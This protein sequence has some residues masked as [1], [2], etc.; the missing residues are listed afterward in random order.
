MFDFHNASTIR[1]HR[2][3]QQAK[4]LLSFKSEDKGHQASLIKGITTQEFEA[5]YPKD[6]YESFSFQA[7]ERF[8]ADLVK[9]NENDLVKAEGQFNEG[10]QN[11]QPVVVENNGSKKLVYV[12]KKD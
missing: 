12:R 3:L 4:M 5:K 11:L 7:I 2:E 8:K 1:S 10:T 6:A 9:A